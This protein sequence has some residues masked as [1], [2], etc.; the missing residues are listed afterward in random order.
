MAVTI[1]GGIGTG[2]G[3][4]GTPGGADTNVQFNDAGAFGGNAGLTYQKASNALSGT[5]PWTLTPASD[6]VPLTV[7]AYSSGTNRIAQ[8]QTSGNA[9]LGGIGHGGEILGSVKTGTDTAADTQTFIGSL[10]TGAGAAGAIVYK[11]GTPQTTGTTQHV[12]A[13]A[14]TL[15]NAGSAGTS[16]PQ[17]LFADGTA[18]KPGAAHLGAPTQ[19]FF[20]RVAGAEGLSFSGSQYYDFSSASLGMFQGIALG[21]GASPLTPDVGLARTAA[22]SLK[23]TNGSTGWGVLNADNLWSD[24]TRTWVGTGQTTRATISGANNVAVGDTAARAVSSGNGLVAVGS[25]AGFSLT[26]EA[27][28]VCLGFQ[29]MFA[30]ANSNS[31]AIGTNALYNGGGGNNVAIGVNALSSTTSVGTDNTVV[32]TSAG[33]NVSTGDQNVLI[34]AAA[35]YSSGGVTANAITT[36]SHCTF[37]GTESGFGSSTQTDNVTTVGYRALSTQANQVSLGNSSVTSLLIGSH[38]FTVG[39]QAFTFGDS[40]ATPLARAYMVGDSARNG[41]DTNVRGGTGTYRSGNGSG[42]GGS[43]DLAE[44]TAYPGA[45]GTTANTYTDRYVAH[46]LWTTLTESS[47]TPVAS[48]TYGAS[49]AVSGDFLVT[50]E[51]NDGTDYQSM[52]YRVRVNSARK[53]TGNTVSTVGVVDGASAP[54]VATTAGGGTLTAT[55]TV[56]EGAGAVTLNCNAVSSLTQTVLRASI[57]VQVNGP[58]TAA[59][60]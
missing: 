44:Q 3:G 2:G 21:W 34:G 60:L 57:Q 53:A 19:G 12:P 54:A 26:T 6:I 38:P 48:L 51:A 49:T 56:T 42:T 24:S 18:A 43:G 40:R 55:F 22:A 27:N 47:A 29:T 8:W 9:D 33:A 17:A 28:S 20:L 31:V 10:G 36:A 7:R 59:Q 52:T 41:V 46:S 23:V 37:L 35:G 16:A 45:S 5:G 13:T 1:N 15:T 50:I 14:L 25:A 4:S 11:V 58:A 32:G 39:A 30:G